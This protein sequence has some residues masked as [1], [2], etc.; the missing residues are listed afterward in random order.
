MRTIVALD[1]E[2]TGLDPKTDAI[3]SIGA[4][5]FSGSRID[6]EFYSLVNPNRRIPPFIT[7]LTG[8]TDHMVYNAPLIHDVLPQVKGFIGEFPVLGHNVNFDVSF[9]KQLGILRWNDLIDTY[10]LA[11]V[12]LPT[13][14]RYNLGSLAHILGVP[15][16][17]K[18]NSLEDARATRGIYLRLYYEAER[19]PLN[20][21]SEIVRLGLNVD[22][23]GDLVFKD[24]LLGKSQ[25][26]DEVP[27]SFRLPGELLRTKNTHV[28]KAL[29]PAPS[30]SPLEPEEVSAIIEP[31][32]EF[33]QH[34][35]LFEYR[36][37]QVE[38]MR[39][40]TKALSDQH[41][42]MV[43]A[44][45]GTGKSVAYLIPAAAWALTNNERVVI[46]TNTIN[47]Q[48]QL[49]HKDIP[50]IR[51]AVGWDFR[52]TVLKGRANY[53]CPR[54]L[55]SLRR[56]GPSNEIEMR[57]I[58]KV[59]VWLSGTQTGDR[60]ELN[61]NGSAERLV[62]EHI[63]AE[64][65][66]CTAENC[67]KQNFGS[68]PFHHAH[69]AAQSAHLII[70]NHALLLA[71]VAS[72]YRVL[73]EY[74]YLIIDEAHHLEDATTNALSFD[75]TQADV[76]RMVKAL[77]GPKSGA[78]GWLLA[79]TQKILEPSEHAAL[80]HLVSGISDHAFHFDLLAQ[81][82]FNALDHFL[83]EQ[84]EGQNIGMYS[85]QVRILSATRIQ[86]SWADVELE[87]DE[88]QHAL[89][90]L[91]E[92]LV[93]IIQGLA[94]ITDSLSIEDED[95]FGTLSGI[96]RHLNEVNTHI[97]GLVFNPDPGRVYWVEAKSD[98]NRLSLH[99][100]PIHIG[101]LMENYIWREKDVVIL[102]SATLTTAGE[103]DYMKHRLNADDAF[104]LALGSPFDYESST[105][106]YLVNDIPEP[107]DRQGH[108][109]SV[110]QSIIDVG[111]A[112]GG[113]TM[114]L[115][116]SY[117]QLNRT[118][119]SISSTLSKEGIQTYVQG[120]GASPHSLL[121]SFRRSEKAVLLGTRSFWEGIDI[122]GETLSSLILVKIP[123]DVP[124]DPIVAARSE[125]FEDPF[126]QYQL[127]EAILRFRQ[128]FGRLI[129]TQYDRGIVVILDKRILTK[130]Y[131]RYFLDSLPTCTVKIG[132]IVELA[133][134]AQQWLNI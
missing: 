94:E 75:V 7:Q 53:I 48:D 116:T 20:I 44:G 118:S 60:S 1:I 57:V 47:L 67:L 109:K 125:S 126:Y 38:M 61:L 74:N 117:D 132:S 124:S 12:L 36:S 22:W 55:E 2:T 3:I 69:L 104:E 76:F 80:N 73:P 77:G 32:G 129:R 49:I 50:D 119:R 102:T 82:F 33:S 58:C 15:H 30:L 86:P 43:E 128:G 28:Y 89:Q 34:F 42:L 81:R 112:I 103:F 134:T 54:R 70:V 16:F 85:Q 93:E 13:T 59:L 120:D 46:S 63:S 91:L 64:D 29:K 106:L 26:L 105:L 123:F 130:G 110:I 31:G 131:G 122:P 92:I 127:P 40:V 62:W 37:Q 121:E 5:K 9:F 23:G 107:N 41:H 84:R 96:Y 101:P 99:A 111:K 95:L 72:G 56:R 14:P 52:A 4:I 11:S 98:S 108:N 66:G 35:P 10:D 87:W 68:C 19:M 133:D 100:A 39:S 51:R 90:S 24:V 115:Y 17:E 83:A 79:A 21:L 18:H 113:R 114:A 71:D 27:E 78:L 97:N 6:D 65:E 45:T 88:S 8:I 25:N